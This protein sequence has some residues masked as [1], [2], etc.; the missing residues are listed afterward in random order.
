MIFE[1][2]QLPKS[3]VSRDIGS[4]EIDG[5]SNVK[6]SVLF[7]FSEVKEDEFGFLLLSNELIGLRSDNRLHRLTLARVH[8][9]GIKVLFIADIFVILNQSND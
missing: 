1:S 6:L 7:L 5:L 3:F 4:W 9:H 2:K 8:A